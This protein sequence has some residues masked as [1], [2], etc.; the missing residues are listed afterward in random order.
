M[1]IPADRHLPNENAKSIKRI[2]R[3]FLKLFDPRDQFEYEIVDQLAMASLNRMRAA[4]FEAML[5]SEIEARIAARSR[6]KNEAIPW[7]MQ[8]DEW[9]SDSREIHA[10]ELRPKYFS[11][12]QDRCARTFHRATAAWATHRR[13]V[14]VKNEANGIPKMQPDLEGGY[15]TLADEIHANEID[16]NKTRG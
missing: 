4:S 9:Q 7:H 6:R 15:S 2:Y 13:A 14:L 16:A 5:R 11:F 3:T 8:S 10:L 12:S 1:N